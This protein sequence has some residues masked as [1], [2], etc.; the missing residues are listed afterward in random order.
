MGVLGMRDLHAQQAY[1]YPRADACIYYV[2][3]DFAIDTFSAYDTEWDL[4]VNRAYDHYRVADDPD[5]CFEVPAGLQNYVSARHVINAGSIYF[6]LVV[7]LLVSVSVAEKVAPKKTM[8]IFWFAFCGF[9]FSELFVEANI[10]SIPTLT[11]FFAGTAAMM[12]EQQLR[13]P[14]S[15]IASETDVP[16]YLYCR[17]VLPRTDA[18]ENRQRVEP[19]QR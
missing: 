2:E 17:D 8:A 4:I 10:L 13:D 1:G 7:V 15:E 9:Y 3:N 14:C 11:G 6:V 18:P 16:F 5:V 12:T 19:E